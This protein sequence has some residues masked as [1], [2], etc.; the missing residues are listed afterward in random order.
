MAAVT[1]STAGPEAPLPQWLLK[2]DAMTIK[3]FILDQFP[4][5]E[6]EGARTDYMTSEG[7]TFSDPPICKT[8]GRGLSNLIWVPP[9]NAEMDQWGERYGDLALSG[10]PQCILVS[11]R[12]RNLYEESGMIGLSGFY[13]VTIDRLVR[14][15]KKCKG[16]PPVYLKADVARSQAGVDDARSGCVWK[17]NST[18]CPECLFPN[19]GI[20]KSW[21]GTVLIEGE[22]P[23]ED[24][25]VPR[26][27]GAGIMVSFRFKAFC[28]EHAILNAWFFPAE[29]YGED[30]YPWENS[31]QV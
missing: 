14:H 19:K 27:G 4:K 10:S 28:E 21:T 13:P 22:V 6:R 24:V 30:F 1:V 25:F 3:Y 5:G 11:E 9:Y 17:K 29:T 2:G 8:C 7:A 16:K 12:F 15:N 26:G 20:I 23:V 31:R 18:I